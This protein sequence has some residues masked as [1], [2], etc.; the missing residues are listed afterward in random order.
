MAGL[1]LLLLR[2]HTAAV[3]IPLVFLAA[4]FV[5]G[6][7]SGFTV[8]A[9]NYTPVRIDP[10]LAAEAIR[11][12]WASR[13]QDPA[14]RVVA[15]WGLC[16]E[17]GRP[18][19]A[20]AFPVRL[21][22]ALLAAGARLQIADP[23]PDGALA[24]LLQGGERV[25]FRDD[26]L[27][28]CDGATELLLASPRPDLLEVDLAAARQRTSGSFLIDCTGRIEPGIYKR[29]GF[30]LLPLYY[31]R[32]P[33]WRD[34]GLRRFIAMV[35]NRVPEDESILLVPTGDF[36]STSPRCRWFLHLN[37]ALAPRPLY[38]LGAAEACGTAE[39]YQG[40]VARMRRMEPAAPETVRRG[41]AAT[42]ARWVLRY[43]HE[44]KFRSGEWEL[45]PAEE[46][47]R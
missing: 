38:L 19:A 7:A 43:R 1:R 45:L 6:F 22:R 37:V 47:L 30:I 46:A 16:E 9:E 41:L 29:T 28:A 21:A 4:L 14:G 44:E 36:A 24:A 18:P 10:E 31:V 20:D 12:G 42:G 5:Q 11:Q 25:V 26:P 27:A 17:D 23:D 3:I 8:R 34:P 39:Q 33:P 32:T 15:F 40:W 13:R 2:L 35:A